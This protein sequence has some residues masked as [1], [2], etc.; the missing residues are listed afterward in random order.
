MQQTIGGV[1]FLLGGAVT[2]L[3]LAAPHGPGVDTGG[4]LILAVALLLAGGVLL[5]LPKRFGP[6]VPPFVIAGA[7]VA[8]TAAVYL[9]GERLGGAPMLNE[10]YYFWPVLYVG[11]FFRRRGIVLSLLAIAVAYGWVLHA[12]G[13]HAETGIQRFNITITCLAGTAAAMQMLRRRIDRLVDKLNTLARTD[14][15]TGLLNRRAFDEGLV[16]EVNRAQRTG[17]AFALV[18]AD[19]DHFKAIND[20]LGHA[21]GD[22]ALKDIA[23]LLTDTARTVD[24]VARIGGEEFALILPGAALAGG[25]ATAERIRDALVGTSLTMSFGVVE[26][27]RDGHHPDDLLRAADSALYAAKAEGRDRTV[28]PGDLRAPAA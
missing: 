15:L 12:I 23:R 8:C 11:Y 14:V 7:I 21:G 19:V 2:L 9:N 4:Y 28:T 3:G 25:V 13:I 10:L 18:L 17:A 22:A 27:P 20:R 6:Y 24:T 26:W 5:V 16:H 1:L